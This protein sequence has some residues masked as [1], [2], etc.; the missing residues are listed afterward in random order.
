MCV[1]LTLTLSLTVLGSVVGQ[2][3]GQT[4]F[5]RRGLSSTAIIP[6]LWGPEGVN[7]DPENSL[8][9]DFTDVGY[10]LSNSPIPDYW[11]ICHNV[12]EYGAVADDNVSDVGAFQAAILDCPTFCAIGVPNGR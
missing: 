9:R 5:L 4:G 3:H 10:N 12:T 1:L 7:W 11:P 2:H 6:D 8:L